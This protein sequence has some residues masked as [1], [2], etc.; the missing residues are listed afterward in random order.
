MIEMIVMPVIVTGALKGMLEIV[1]RGLSK[2]RL[3]L[4]GPLK[5]SYWI[6]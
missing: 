3:S 5:L 6:H 1:V 2:Q 4:N